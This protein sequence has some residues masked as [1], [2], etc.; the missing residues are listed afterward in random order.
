MI[1]GRRSLLFLGLLVSGSRLW[2]GLGNRGGVGGW[3][4]YLGE[5]ELWEGVCLGLGEGELWWVRGA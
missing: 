5:G 3:G 2:R 4:G 1:G